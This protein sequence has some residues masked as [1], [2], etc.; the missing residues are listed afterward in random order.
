MCFSHGLLFSHKF[1]SI[2]KEIGELL[3]R[4]PKESEMLTSVL[5]TLQAAKDPEK[6]RN[7]QT[8]CVTLPISLPAK[9]PGAMSKQSGH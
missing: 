2:F 8:D 5:I 4:V 6:N 9:D 3:F 7:P 1:P